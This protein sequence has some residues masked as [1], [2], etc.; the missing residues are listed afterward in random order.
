MLN[1]LRNGKLAPG[2]LTTVAGQDGGPAVKLVKPAAQA[3]IALCAAALAEGHT[4]KATSAADSYR[5]FDAQETVFRERYTQDKLPGRPF[6]TW[7][8]KRWYQKPGTA[9]AAVP[10]TSNHGWGL[11]V[12]TGEERDHD[13]GTERLSAAALTWLV[14]NEKRFGFSHEVQ[15]ERWHI[16][17]FAGDSIP[18]AVLAHLNGDDMPLTD[19]DVTKTWEL[20]GIIDN[21]PWRTDAAT[22]RK[23]K[24]SSAVEISM[25][26]AHEARTE[27]HEANTKA[28]KIL[29]A[30][31]AAAQVN[32]ATLA[33]IKALTEAQAGKVDTDA[34]I[35][36]IKE[37]GDRESTAVAALREEIAALQAQLAAG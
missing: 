33:A 10:G 30:L 37:V 24:P 12:D 22:N 26:E 36:A 15:S 19:A 13:D 14:A 3:W 31:A 32:D 1:G 34:V 2:I 18:A 35:A 11:A 23:I 21:R 5:S 9:L 29:A 8:G 20:D 17:Y 28:D 4:L 7:Q 16:R 25:D 6:K 27:A